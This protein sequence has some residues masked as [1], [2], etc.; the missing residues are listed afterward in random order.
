MKSALVPP[1][2]SPEWHDFYTNAIAHVHA[3]ILQDLSPPFMTEAFQVKHNN[4]MRA[5]TRATFLNWKADT[6][7]KVFGPKITGAFRRLATR[8]DLKLASVPGRPL[9]GCPA[10]SRSAP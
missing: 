10:D 1:P 5:Y 3:L 9:V 6:A 8:Y 7:A 2:G 4:R